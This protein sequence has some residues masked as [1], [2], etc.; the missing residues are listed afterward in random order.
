[1]L[2]VWKATPVIPFRRNSH[3]VKAITAWHA[4]TGRPIYRLIFSQ[5]GMPL[6]VDAPCLAHLLSTSNSRAAR[7]NQR[8]GVAAGLAD[9]D[10][11]PARLLSTSW[12]LAASHTLHADVPAQIRTEEELIISWADMQTTD[13]CAVAIRPISRMDAR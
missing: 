12:M 8:S 4:I 10:Q 2:A 11:H 6:A 3:V 9:G 7:R 13:D 5:T 1:M